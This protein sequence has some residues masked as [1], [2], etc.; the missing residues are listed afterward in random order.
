ME[1]KENK[2]KLKNNKNTVI[3]NRVM[4]VLITATIRNIVE[5]VNN[6]DIKKD[7]IVSLLKENGQYI[8]I[9]YK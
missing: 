1:S 3:D 9:Y 5:E 7:N 8:L 2:K 6:R 4:A